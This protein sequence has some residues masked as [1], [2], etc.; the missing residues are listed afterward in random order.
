MLLSKHGYLYRLFRSVTLGRE[1]ASQEVW[2]AIF[3]SH[4]I[5]PNIIK[6]HNF[7]PF[8]S[9]IAEGLRAR[10]SESSLCMYL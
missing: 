9:A 10:I 1:W 2:S 6:Q 8:L 7:D 5:C 3:I 4:C